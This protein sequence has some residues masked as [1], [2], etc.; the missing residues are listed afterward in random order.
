MERV[1][2]IDPS[3]PGI[4][5]KRRGRGF[6][7]LDAAGRRIDDPETLERIRALVLP[8]AW[9]DVW[10]CADPLGHLQA[11]GFDAAGRKQYRYHDLWR[12]RRD[13]SKHR[14]IEAFAEELPKLRRRVARDLTEPGLTRRRVLAG[15][16]RMLDTVALRIGGEE[17]AKRN[18]SYGLATLHRDHLRFLDHRAELRFNGKGSKEQFVEINDPKVVQLLH[19]LS[20]VE[21]DKLLIWLAG[22]RPRAIRSQDVNDY[23]RNSLGDGFSAKDFRTWNATV[24]AAALLSQREVSEGRRAVTSVIKEV[25]AHLGNTPAVCRASYVDPRIIDRFLDQGEMIRPEGR[26]RRSIEEAVLRLLRPDHSE[27]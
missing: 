16:V 11:T 6:A 18:G 13:R 10:I 27:G 19:E 9:E 8:P 17:Y 4:S 24:L 3:R 7:Y 23:I 26:G 12:A 2:R 20:A 15:A 22:E 5:R 25:A 14:R 1:H 21:A